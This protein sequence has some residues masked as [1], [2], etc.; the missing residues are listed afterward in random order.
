MGSVQY[1]PITE[2]SKVQTFVQFASPQGT[3]TLLQTQLNTSFGAQAGNIQ[4]F[5][6]TTGG[7]TSNAVVVVG[8]AAVFSVPPN[9]WITYFNGQWAQYTPAQL[10]ATFTQ[11]F[12]T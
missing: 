6:D 4:C 1:L 7:Q 8:D 5:A 3:T 12:L 10:A 11:Y 9:N 2:V